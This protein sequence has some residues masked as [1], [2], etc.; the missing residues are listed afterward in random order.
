MA[1]HAHVCAL[2]CHISRKETRII[3]MKRMPKPSIL[4][5]YEGHANHCGLISNSTTP[6]SVSGVDNCAFRNAVMRSRPLSISG[7]LSVIISICPESKGYRGS[8]V[9]TRL[10]IYGL[11]PTN[12]N[13]ANTEIN[14]VTK[15]Y[16]ANFRSR[17]H[18]YAVMITTQITIAKRNE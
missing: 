14:A 5:S 10:V 4:A 7:V 3:G 13:P 11:K 17:F 2:D 1:T 15:A 12:N 6:H 9:V 8:P 16:P 18:K